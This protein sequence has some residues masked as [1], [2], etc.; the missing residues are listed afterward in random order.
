MDEMF[1]TSDMQSLRRGRRVA[2]RTPVCRPCLVWEKDGSPSPF[3]GVAMDMSPYGFRIRMLEALPP[4]ARIVVQMMR[5]DD[6][7]EPLS[8]PVEGR[9]VRVQTN[10]EALTDHGVQLVQR[11]IRR[12]QPRPVQVDRR[13]SRRTRRTRM[14]SFDVTVG[15]RRRGRFRR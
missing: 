3:Q 9:V 10:T 2:S 1:F 13:P 15:E 8:K 7:E 6:F 5:D 4:D 11:D 14:Y 12:I